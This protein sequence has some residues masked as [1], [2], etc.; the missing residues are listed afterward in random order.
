M[1]AVPPDWAR[2][3]WLLGRAN[4]VAQP[5]LPNGRFFDLLG[6]RPALFWD[7]AV[8]TRTV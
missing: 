2:L 7:W 3:S 8:P 5:L 6:Q 1:G 4:E